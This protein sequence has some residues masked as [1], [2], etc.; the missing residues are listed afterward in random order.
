MEIDNRSRRLGDELKKI[1]LP[2]S[3][4]KMAAATFSL[5]A[6][7]ELREALEEIDEFKF[8]FTNPAFMVDE[9][10][11][12]YREYAIPKAERE[13][14]LFGASYELK[15]MN[16]LTQ[17]AIAK[18]CAEWV[19]RKAEFK[20]IKVDEPISDGVRIECGSN[21]F[22][23]DR[24]KNFD[25][26]ELG[27]EASTLKTRRNLYE[28]PNSLD[29]LAEFEDYWN[30]NE[31]FRDIT[32]EVLDKLNIAYKEHS[33]EF[34][35]YVMLYNLFSDFLEDVNQDYLP[36]EGVK[37]KQSKV[38]NMLY[39]FQKDAVVSIISKLE[40]YNGCIL[41]DSVGLGKTF[42]ALAVMTYYA[43]RGKRILVLCPKKLEANWNQ[44]RHDYISNPI[45]DRYL[46]YDVLY[47][48]DLSRDMGHSN[49]IDLA[50]NRWD[51]YDLV[52][53]DE[54]H[55]FRNGGSQ[56]DETGKENRYARLM[57]RII[58]EGV[59]TKVLMLS[60]T[61]VNN[62]FNDLKNQLALA[63]EGN[64]A[65]M[66]EKLDTESSLND[67]FRQAQAAYNKWSSLPVEERTTET[68]LKSLD[69]DFFKVLDSVTIARSRQH[70]RDFYDTSAIGH[71]PTRMKPINYEPNL[72]VSDMGITY[73]RIYGLLDQLNL[74]IYQ[75][76]NYMYPSR[77][78]KYGANNS[79]SRNLTQQGREAGIKKLMMMSLLKRLESS[80]EAFRYTLVEVV[81]AYIEKTLKII[82]DYQRFG[83]FTKIES[84]VINEDD[85]DI[86]ESNL[87]FMVG[88]K[89]SIQLEDINYQAWKIDL[90]SD[91]A[92]LDELEKLVNHIC[93]EQDMKLQTL[94]TVIDDKMSHPL[95]P[96][97][98]KLIIF[99]AFATTTEY[100]YKQISHYVYER[101]GLYAAQISGAKGVKTTLPLKSGGQDYNTVLT[102]FS[103]K[104]KNRGTIFPNDNREIDIL[105]A[106]D[107]I[108]EGQNLQDADMLV[109]YDI[110]WNPVR[111][112]QRF[113]RIDRIGS[114]N[115]KIQLINF[116]PSIALDDY[117]KLR[118][119]VE[120]R[121]K[122][123]VLTSTG[124]DN[125]LS[126]E[127]VA[128]NDYRKAQLS[129][130]RDEVV[131][132][133]DMNEGISI[134]DLGLEDY[135]MDLNQYLIKH[136]QLKQAP[137]GLQA[138]VSV[139][140]E[141][142]D[143]VIFVLKEKSSDMAKK[144]KNRLY[145]YYILYVNKEGEVVVPIS[146]SRQLLEKIRLL[147]RGKKEPLSNL[148]AKY[149]YETQEGKRMGVYT[150]LLQD[151]IQ[152]VSDEQ[153]ENFITSLFSSGKVSF[154]LA[155][156]EDDF[157][158]LCFFVL[159]K[160]EK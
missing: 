44:Y 29:Y 42:T 74:A 8:I 45:Y 81:K 111:I 15:L 52:V 28:A 105:I 47:H 119:R 72:T 80:V 152:S 141:S 35:Y 133:E 145:P 121:M 5:Y 63:Y 139:P 94:K 43:Y 62:R 101:Y 147:C 6:F 77:L 125:L 57:N 68:L 25:R 24:L 4:V 143:G 106:T 144:Q 160:E 7:Q 158:L 92:I 3:Q 55:N 37:Y 40:K 21:V 129:R 99:S 127:E 136:P 34:L 142:S 75:P 138:I 82:Q 27:Y 89:V 132:L 140:D 134:M 22:S 110:H 70:V 46:Q 66:D 56:D 104:S 146:D 33:P 17:K 112:V 96:G 151:A 10:K 157:E 31:Y 11:E 79:R 114:H 69:F 87:D 149:N 49:G 12:Q 59:P 64:V 90:E 118:S 86:D 26:K 16:E 41:A 128:E 9:I 137:K 156:T 120:S 93:P 76:T 85:L 2:H 51:T 116:W 108:S 67:I 109:N 103:P 18:E 58:R 38:W 50:Q 60:A 95:N 84:Q 135:R 124:D 30:D 153:T 100:I 14:A 122:V 126:D 1:I 148:V 98:K 32:Q 65:K 83:G 78:G 123:T 53:I 13:M 54:S 36:N 130:L 61:P 48:T 20:T 88:K 91:Y 73:E 71:F 107:V 131:D 102:Y 159:M 115:E 155:T 39:D 154:D 150:K 97:N 23:V 19:R 117:I 113:G